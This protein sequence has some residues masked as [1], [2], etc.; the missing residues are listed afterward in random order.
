M[1]TI[2]SGDAIRTGGAAKVIDERAWHDKRSCGIRSRSFMARRRGGV[3]AS[4]RS[5]PADRCPPTT[6]PTLAGCS[7]PRGNG[8]KERWPRVSVERRL[9][10]G[11]E[12]GS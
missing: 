6:P 2:S 7:H 8:M 1:E 12:Q 4:G 5:L 10:G 9:H 3:P 11:R